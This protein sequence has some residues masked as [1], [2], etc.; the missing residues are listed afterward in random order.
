[1]A[2]A[3]H[4]MRSRAPPV[5]PYCESQPV[6]PIIQL[7]IFS[8]PDAE[9]S[10]D[11]THDPR[12]ARSTHLGGAMPRPAPAHS[13]TRPLTSFP[14]NMVDSICQAS[15]RPIPLQYHHRT[16]PR[17]SIVAVPLANISEILLAILHRRP[18][19]VPRL[20]SKPCWITASMRRS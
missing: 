6:N 16:T 13:E 2:R 11:T 8:I 10:L 1:M 20:A 9:R 14:S 17:E 19:R 12:S 3:N 4:S 15:Q 7:V 18:L 5:L